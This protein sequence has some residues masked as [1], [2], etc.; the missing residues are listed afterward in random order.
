M[1]VKAVEAA[2]SEAVER[3]YREALT[4]PAVERHVRSASFRIRLNFASPAL[5]DEFLPSFLPGGEGDIDLTLAIL[6]AADVDLSRVV[7]APAKEF[8]HFAGESC[9]ALWQPDPAPTLYAF[10]R[11]AARA[12]IWLAGNAA[13]PWLYGKPAGPIMHALAVP[14]PWVGVH[15]GAVARGGRTLLLAGKGKAGKSTAAL[16][17]ARAGWTFAGDDFVFAHS[18]DGRIAPL[19]CT[20]RLRGDVAPAF[21]ELMAASR[22]IS[23]VF[24]DLRHELRLA[25]VMPMDRFGGGTLAVILLPRRQGAA[26]VTF[27]PARRFDAMSALLRVSVEEQPGWPDTIREKIARLVELA[28]V[29]TV[30]TGPDPAAIPAAFALFLDRLQ[31]GLPVAG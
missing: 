2:L 12:V 21:P 10:D 29:F 22:R 13:A 14:T 11:R 24:G 15:A 7:P 26:R 20:A 16:A 19:N 4:P 27:A 31:E 17:C 6:T 25:D 9:F 23:E 8:R 5:A 28:P 30:D 18:I 3:A 1:P